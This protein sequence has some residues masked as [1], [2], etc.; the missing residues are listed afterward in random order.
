MTGGTGA[1]V[2]GAG[3]AGFLLVPRI[4]LQA[5]MEMTALVNLLIG[6]AAVG[7]AKLRRIAKADAGPA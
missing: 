5:T 6:G 4:G 1:T 3:L 7:I 2:T